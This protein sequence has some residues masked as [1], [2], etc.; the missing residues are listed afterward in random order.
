[1]TVARRNLLL[2]LVPMLVLAGCTT[3][4]DLPSATESPAVSPPPAPMLV[5]QKPVDACEAPVQTQ[6]VADSFE[7][8]DGYDEI[9]ITYHDSGEG[10]VSL[11]IRNK[12]S[13]E[14]VYGFTDRLVNSV[15]AGVTC[16][17]HAHSGGGET[18]AVEPGTFDVAISYT[19]AV[20]LHL[21]VVA[22]STRM[23]ESMDHDH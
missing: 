19:G 21:E 17:G 11:Q 18:R 15:A 14:E 1:M 10:R 2:G 5:Y 9:I 8:A 7:V 4:G 13:G 22:R 23:N 12:A 6:P 3:A 20:A 16:G